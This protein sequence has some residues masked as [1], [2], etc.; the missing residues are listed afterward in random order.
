MV[1]GRSGLGEDLVEENLGL[2]L[3]ALLRQSH[4]ADQDVTGLREHALLSGRETALALATPEVTNNL[5]NLEGV[6][7]GELLEIGLVTPRPV[8][9]LLGVRSAEDVEDL[10]QALLADHLAHADD[11]GVLSGH[12]DRQVPLSDPEDEVL[13][14]HALDRPSLDCLDECGP[15]VGVNNGLADTENH[16]FET[17]FAVPRVT[18]SGTDV[19]PR[20]SLLVQLRGP[21]RGLSPA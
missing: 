18:R 8:G 19:S 20:P 4:L 7:A 14:L 17:P 9:R 10:A 15:V 13:L 11:L 2:V 16:R 5:G 3:R 1:M 6:T 21:V 12:T